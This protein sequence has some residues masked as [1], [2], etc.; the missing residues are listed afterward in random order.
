M[1]WAKVCLQVGLNHPLP[2]FFFTPNSAMHDAKRECPFGFGI[3]RLLQPVLM[4]GSITK[5]SKY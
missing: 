4:L 5:V 2:F 3:D 1:G